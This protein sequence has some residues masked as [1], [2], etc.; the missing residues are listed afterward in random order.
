MKAKHIFVLI[1]MCGLAAASIGVTINCAGVFYGPIA[2]DLGV[3]RGSVSMMITITSIVA[4]I[5][6]MFIPKKI[7]EKNLKLMII[8]A[9][10]LLAGMSFLISTSKSVFM[11]YVFSIFRG[12]GDGIINFVLITMIVNFW[13]YANRGIFTSVVMAFSGVPGVILSPIFTNIINASGWRT[14][15]V[16]VAIF[17]VAFCLPAILLPI[18]IRP[19]TAGI[20]PYGYEEYLKAKEEGK[21][22]AISGANPRFNFLNPKFFLMI[23]ICLA[24]NTVAA[25]PQHL[26]GYAVSLGKA[27]SVGALMLSVSMAC[28]IASKIIFGILNDKLG[29]YKAIYINAIINIGGICLLLFVGQEWALY[30]GSGMFATTYAVSAVG[31]AMIAGY[32]FGMEYY[33]TVYP[34]ISFI[35]GIANAV[36]ISLLGS[37]YDTTGTYTIDFWIALVCQII[38]I[39]ATVLA[40]GI[41]H[42]ER[43]SGIENV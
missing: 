20:Q 32:L 8:V 34:I 41:R 16:Y 21:I 33:G 7:N 13:F 38:L 15:F 1:A 36:A 35:G 5:G 11:L 27:A 31:M 19:E 29:S 37:L 39:V 28:N 26:P 3:G 14:G 42:K 25:V 22:S 17:T 43:R 2:E 23:F 12:L 6:A 10:A 24:T 4:S 40:V 9:T 30:A 18:T